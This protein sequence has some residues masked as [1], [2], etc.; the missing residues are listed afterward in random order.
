MLLFYIKSFLLFDTMVGF[1]CA[2]T[3]AKIFGFVLILRQ[4]AALAG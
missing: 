1:A 3:I 4:T 2:F